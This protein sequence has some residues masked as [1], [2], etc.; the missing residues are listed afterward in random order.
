MKDN[1]S[2]S[3]KDAAG[4]IEIFLDGATSPAQEDALYAFYRRH[5]SGTLPDELEKY[6]AMIQWY[7]SL[8]PN[9][10]SGKPFGYIWSRLRYV[11][12]SCGVACIV[13]AILLV[14][15][16]GHASSNQLYAQYDGSYVIRNGQRISDMDAI[17][18]AILKAERIADSLETIANLREEFVDTEYDRELVEA[19]LANVADVRLASELK[20]QLLND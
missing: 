18:P 17:F 8:K 19:A 9:K 13:V 3:V 11:A 16:T 2:L 1:K 14:S 10:A 20:S 5:K 6:R 15:K 12:V 4:L 7:W